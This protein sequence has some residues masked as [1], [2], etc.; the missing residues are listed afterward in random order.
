MLLC[1]FSAAQRWGRE[2]HHFYVAFDQIKKRKEKRKIQWATSRSSREQNR[3][4]EKGRAISI[5]IRKGQ[6]NFNG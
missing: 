1:P 4:E 3:D 6:G 5:D 2:G